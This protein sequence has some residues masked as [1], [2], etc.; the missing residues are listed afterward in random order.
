MLYPP[1]LRAHYFP[2]LPAGALKDNESLPMRSLITLLPLL[3]FALAAQDWKTATDLPALDMGGLTPVQK[4]AVLKL[5]R[6]ES[7][8]CTCGMKVAECRIKD[9]AC[10][11]S[12]LLAAMA[13]A[14]MRAAGGASND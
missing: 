11:D 10:S 1:E 3:A 8:A 9:P 2:I 5:L 12:R 7:C 4:T 6:E 13:A 14:E